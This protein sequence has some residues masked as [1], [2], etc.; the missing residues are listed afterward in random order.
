[1]QMD[2]GDLIT[3]LWRRKLIAAPAFALAFGLAG[4]YLVL[5][6]ARYAADM[7]IL[8][9]TRERPPAGADTA[10]I[11]QN[12]DPAVVEGQMRLLKSNAVLR[13]VVENQALLTDPEFAPKRSPLMDTL[14]ALIGLK[15]TAPGVAAE[16]VIEALDK[17][18]SIKRS[19]KSY[20]LDV[21]VLASSP[22]RAEQFARALSDAYFETQ[23]RIADDIVDREAEWLD[24]KLKDLRDR[25]EAA[26]RRAEEFR[27]A[28][29]LLVTDGHILPEEQL[30]D[31]NSALIEARGKRAEQ[32]ARYAQLRAAIR[33]GGSI[34]TLGDAIHST[35]IE[36]L[37]GDYAAL[38]KD[39]AFAQSTL[40]PRHPSYVIVRAQVEALR[41]QISAELKR[42]SASM[43]HDLR[44]ARE[45]EQAAA[46][47]V[48][49]LSAQIDRQGGGRLEYGELLR[50]AA[51][52]RDQYEKA[53][54]AR[55][56]LRKDIVGS[57]N[58]VVINQPL[59]QKGRA[60][61]KTLPALL[62]ASAGGLNLFVVAALIAE[63]LARRRRSLAPPP[64]SREEAPA[65]P[66]PK[67]AIPTKPPQVW[68]LP[69]FDP[70]STRA[71]APREQ[72]ERLVEVMRSPGDPYRGAI[73][74][75]YDA[76]WR[77]WTARA[78]PVVVVAGN[79]QGVGVSTVASALAL[80]ACAQGERALLLEADGDDSAFADLPAGSSRTGGLS[81]LHSE[82]EGSGRVMLG[83]I[84]Q[85]TGGW[86]RG[87]L[88]KSRY[89]LIVV[90]CGALKGDR[91][92][93][94][95]E[96][97]DVALMIERSRDGERS[98]VALFREEAG[99]A[100]A[101]ERRA[102]RRAGAA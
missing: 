19:E 49:D 51:A 74:E 36:K 82:A 89:D 91:A 73:T 55:E 1:M 76:L 60:S 2:A 93:V 44:A 68:R 61:P 31:A 38:S 8:V 80:F 102:R 21:E 33:A 48:A 57:P 59:A 77:E 75:I 97:V 65:R 69:P 13:R 35:L 85:R 56:N 79:E 41:R 70:R 10:P 11:A 66:T 47:V 27:K 64:P 7:A 32:E 46:R 101:T 53:L 6:P 25:L 45:S 17:A 100:S 30:K 87:A 62:I 84:D 5:T 12:P 54:V 18:I 99:E 86:P 78:A 92:L 9:D 96:L 39:A 72:F 58:G 37:R 40:G 29:S 14:R 67:G 28:Q 95:D 15:P 98:V 3:A 16:G 81:E 22:E 52:L 90:D 63:Y 4:A 88:F 26:E 42:I 71:G 43:E 83:R 24:N 20:V 23:A 94:P 50:K 34:D